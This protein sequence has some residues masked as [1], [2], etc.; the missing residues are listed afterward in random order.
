M[1]NTHITVIKNLS[2]LSTKVD[3]SEEET[4]EKKTDVTINGHIEQ[5]Y[6][7]GVDKDMRELQ[8]TIRSMQNSAH[9]PLR[10]FTIHN[11]IE[12]YVEL[13]LIFSSLV[14]L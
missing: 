14:V 13:I 6:C 2:D 4:S 8:E 12:K 7:T 1:I 11:A 5:P 10:I 3:E 9:Q